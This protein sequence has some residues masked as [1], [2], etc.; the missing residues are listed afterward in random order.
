MDLKDIN[1]IKAAIKYMDYRPALLAK[2]YDVKSLLF[3]EIVEHEEYYKVS[4]IMPNPLNDNRIV[5]CINILDKKFIGSREVC[6]GTKT[7]ICMPKEAVSILNSIATKV[8][9]A[10]ISLSV[11]SDITADV[12]LSVPRGNCVTVKSMKLGSDVWL[13]VMNSFNTYTSEG[14]TLAIHMEKMSI[15]IEP[16]ALDGIKGQG[17]V[18]VYVMTENAIYKDFASK[19]FNTEDILSLYRG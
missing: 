17:D 8:D 14:F 16:S 2:F 10:E 6:D 11:G 1:E 15:S 13:G 5:K 18:F 3:R 12:Y 19:Y 9:G 7:A 4:S